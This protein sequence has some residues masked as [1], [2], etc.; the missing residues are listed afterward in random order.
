[1]LISP[2]KHILPYSFVLIDLCSNNVAEYQALILGLQMAIGMGIK[3]L[4]VWGDS[5]LVINQL[6]EEFEVK[7]D[8]LIPHH[9]NALQL[10]DKPETVK[11]EHVP[12]SANKMADVLV[13][14]AATF[15]LG[16]DES[17]AILVCGQWVVTPPV[18]EGAKEVKTKIQRRASRFLYYKGTLYRCAF[19]G[20]WLQCLDNE[21]GKQVMEEAH[22]SVCG[23]HQLGPKLHDHVKRTGYY[24]PT[25]VRDFINSARRCD[26]CQLHANFIDQPPESLHPIIAS[27]PFEAWG[28]DV[29]RLFTLK[30]STG[31]TYILACTDYF[32]KWAEAIAFKEVK[33]ENVVDFCPPRYVVTDNGKLFVKKLMSR[34]CEK[35]KFSQHK[36]SMYNA[37]TNSLAK[38]FNKTLRNL[39]K[40]VVFKSKWN[41]YEKLREVLWAYRTSYRTPTQSTP[42]ALVYGVEAIF[43]LEIQI[44]SLHIA[45]QEGL[46]RD[47]NDQLWLAEL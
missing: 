2:E 31:Y 8:N 1:V 13:N 18:D 39:L 46:H 47:E 42:Y 28:L 41:W 3:D 45:M 16:I 6:L 10:L 27:L 23:A 33:K 30:S 20:L 7:K 21:E 22:V 15:A 32:F 25:M 43:P 5:H 9:N 29:V 35:F 37:P 36:S 14:L 38:A 40:K 19:L 17:I 34:L 44:T 12:R 26:I 24:R 4:D 11:L